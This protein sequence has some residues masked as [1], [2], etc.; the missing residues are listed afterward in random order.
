MLTLAII[1]TSAHDKIVEVTRIDPSITVEQLEF[2]MHEVLF[3][4]PAHFTARVQF[5]K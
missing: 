4:A 3:N 5:E 1:D 2:Q